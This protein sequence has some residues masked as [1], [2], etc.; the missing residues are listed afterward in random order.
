MPI[1]IQRHLSGNSVGT[2]SWGNQF[3]LRRICPEIWHFIFIPRIPK[4]TSS[5]IPGKLLWSEGIESE[6]LPWMRKL[7][8]WHLTSTDQISSKVLCVIGISFIPHLTTPL[9]CIWLNL[10][11]PSEVCISSSSSGGFLN[12]SVFGKLCCSWILPI[13]CLKMEAG[14]YALHHLFHY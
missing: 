4:L 6:N 12:A 7:G 1:Y 5:S 9:S 3:V 2:L 13:M 8:S 11:Y 10:P 14:K